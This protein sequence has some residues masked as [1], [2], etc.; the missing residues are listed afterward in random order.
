MMFEYNIPNVLVLW[1][2]IG[3]FLIC[4]V[5]GLLGSIYMLVCELLFIKNKLFEKLTY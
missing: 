2:I 4:I 5:G 3:F 1:P